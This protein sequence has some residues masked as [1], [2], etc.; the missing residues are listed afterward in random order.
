MSLLTLLLANQGM[1][2][3]QS[4]GGQ[5]LSSAQE[6]EKAAKTLLPVVSAAIKKQ[7]GSKKEL[8]DFLEKADRATLERYLNDPTAAATETILPDSE[9]VLSNILRITGDRAGLVS[10]LAASSGLPAL[11]IG[12]LLPVVAM[13]AVGAVAKNVTEQQKDDLRASLPSS[14]GVSRLWGFFGRVL[15]KPSTT[16][17]GAQILGTMIES[18]VSH[19]EQWVVDAFQSD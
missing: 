8:L 17:A 5:Y 16:H 15:S 10:K 1:K 18:G 19:E 12:R 3:I 13:L 7:T 4:V 2:L 9:S 14:S 11:A 6:A